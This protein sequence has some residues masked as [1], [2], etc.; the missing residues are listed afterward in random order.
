MII[1][2]DSSISELINIMFDNNSSLINKLKDSIMSDRI[3]SNTK[4]NSKLPLII[5]FVCC[6]YNDSLLITKPHDA[7][8]IH[9][10]EVRQFFNHL[11]SDFQPI[12]ETNG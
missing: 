8:V 12:S 7:L 10:N 5:K 11:I 6:K 9:L 2:F 3:K 1:T 4:I